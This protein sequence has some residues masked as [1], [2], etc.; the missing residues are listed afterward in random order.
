MSDV[1]RLD[2]QPRP[3]A[4]GGL[5]EREAVERLFGRWIDIFG[6]KEIRH[7][8]AREYARDTMDNLLDNIRILPAAQPAQRVKPLVWRPYGYQGQ[9]MEASACGLETFYRIDGKPGDWTLTSPGERSYVHTPGYATRTDAKVAATVDFE[10]RMTAHMEPAAPDG[11]EVER[12]RAQLTEMSAQYTRACQI[13]DKTCAERDALKGEVERLREFEAFHLSDGGH[14]DPITATRATA[15]QF[16]HPADGGGMKPMRS[17]CTCDEPWCKACASAAAAPD[18]AEVAMAECQEFSAGYE[19]G[20]K[21]TAGG[22]ELAK[23]RT[24]VERLRKAL[25]DEQDSADEMADVL[26]ECGDG[27]MFDVDRLQAALDQHDALREAALCAEQK[28]NA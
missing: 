22:E 16:G 11:A 24:E 1:T 3:P 9:G 18:G 20:E 15:G 28:G 21:A 25:G 12:L 4:V 2:G 10:R 6:G 19:A 17:A 23:L 14:L 8:S 27:L 7:T 26:S 5:I 13:V